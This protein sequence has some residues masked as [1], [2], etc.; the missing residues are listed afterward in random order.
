MIKKETEQQILRDYQVVNSKIMNNR[1]YQLVEI[2]SPNITREAR[3]KFLRKILNRT[4]AIGLIEWWTGGIIRK[5]R[6]R[7]RCILVFKFS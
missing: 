6:Q 4:G 7:F 2:C 1:V 5:P 3:S